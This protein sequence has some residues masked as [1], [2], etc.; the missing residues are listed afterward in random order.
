[1]RRV[2]SSITPRVCGAIL[3]C[4]CLLFTAT[5]TFADAATWYP[6]GYPHATGEQYLAATTQAAH[7]H[8]MATTSN[9]LNP[10]VQGVRFFQKFI[11]PV[12]GPRCPMYP[13]CS[14][15]ALQALQRHG[16]VLGSFLSVDRLLHE[17]TP[18]EQTIPLQG[19]ERLRYY[20]PLDANDFWLNSVKAQEK[21]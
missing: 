11:S 5:S 13:T 10:L 1:M 6:P 20:D 4:A 16:P 17:T 9:E 15:Y 19:F 14:T 18:A 3:V 2:R 21:L 8:P 12:D 7:T